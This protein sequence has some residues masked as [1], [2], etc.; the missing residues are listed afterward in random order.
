MNNFKQFTINSYTPFTDNINTFG[1]FTRIP[2]P[3]ARA[4]S[5]SQNSFKTRAH[6]VEKAKYWQF[7]CELP[8]V[9]SDSFQVN[10]KNN[11]IL[12]KGTRRVASEEPFNLKFDFPFDLY[13]DNF[14]AEIKDGVLI[15]LL[16]KNPNFKKEKTIEPIQKMTLLNFLFGPY[17][18]EDSS[19][20]S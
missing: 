14:K 4:I 2:T 12:I 10:K 5:N 3:I 19:K 13:C 1:E 11:T 15:L 16:F 17:K 6:V 20:A 18:S 7:V 9:S 8:G